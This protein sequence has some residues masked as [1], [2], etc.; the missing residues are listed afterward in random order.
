MRKRVCVS[1]HLPWPILNVKMKVCLLAN[2]AVTYCIEFCCT[3]YIPQWVVIS[4]YCKRR[5]IVQIVSEFITNCPFQIKKLQLSRVQMIVF[6]WWSES[7]G[8][9]SCDT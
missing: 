4:M 1:V 5:S 2:I 9:I 6:Y 8:A 7:S 3:K